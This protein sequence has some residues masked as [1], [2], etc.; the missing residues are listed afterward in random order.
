ML[1]SGPPPQYRILVPRKATA[2]VTMGF[3]AFFAFLGSGGHTSDLPRDPSLSGHPSTLTATRMST[4]CA[5][6]QLVVTFDGSMSAL[7]NEYGVFSLRSASRKTCSMFGYPGVR[8]QDPRGRPLPTHAERAGVPPWQKGN[9]GH[10]EQVMLGP[11][12]KASFQLSWDTSATLPGCRP[13]VHPDQLAITPPDGSRPAHVAAHDAHGRD[14]DVCG[15]RLLVSSV[16]GP[17]HY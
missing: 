6:D 2:F 10:E 8:M 3:G 13:D 1:I 16:S 4:R 17:P 12:E 5:A 15:G 9:D 7:G 11:G 14:M